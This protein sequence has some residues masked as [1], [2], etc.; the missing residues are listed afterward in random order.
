[1]GANFHTPAPNTYTLAGDFDKKPQFHMG[2]R[3]GG[4]GNKNLDQ[5]G[6]GEYET[7]VVPL[8]HSNLQ[9]VIGTGFRGDLGVGK[10]HLYPGPGEYEVRG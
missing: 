8:H 5:P 10:S 1:M 4:R 7:D 3:T 6:P 2:I 9:H